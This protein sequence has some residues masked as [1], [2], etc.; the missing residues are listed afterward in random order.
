MSSPSRSVLLVVSG[1]A[2]VGK[3]T[4]CDRMV[5]SHPSIHRFV[6]TTSRPPR[7]G[8]VD[9]VDYHFLERARFEAQIEEGAFLEWAN[10]HGNLY[11]TQRAQVHAALEAGQDLLFNIDVQGAQNYREAATEDRVIAERLVTVFLRPQSLDQIRA[12]LTA[13]GSDDAASIARRLETAERELTAAGEFDHVITSGSK[14]AD[15]TALQ[16]IYLQAKSA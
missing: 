6:T 15:F 4:L 2:G 8:E 5:A 16:T 10:V 11:G 1:P 14:E 3:T 12:R 7:S 13:R 9:G